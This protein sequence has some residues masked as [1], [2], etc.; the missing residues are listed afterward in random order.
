MA[1]GAGSGSELP[2]SSSRDNHSKEP[3]IANRPWIELSAR[4]CQIS[5]LYAASADEEHVEI[6]WDPGGSI[7]DPHTV[8]PNDTTNGL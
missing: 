6:S 8:F 5:G 4:S 3:M 7:Y 2:G 1:G